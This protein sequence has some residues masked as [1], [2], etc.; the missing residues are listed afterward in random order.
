MEKIMPEY[1][2]SNKN[3]SM[4]Y[5]CN[6]IESEKCLILIHGYMGGWESWKS[7]IQE[8]S[9]YKIYALDLLGFNKSGPLN[10]YNLESWTN[11]II[12]FINTIESK[13]IYVIGHSLGALITFNIANKMSNKI[14]G[15]FLEEPGWIPEF[16][17]MDM[18]E[19]G[20]IPFI[21]KH[22]NEWKTAND[23]VH[24]FREMDPE[25]FDLEPFK[26]SLRAIYIFNADMNVFKLKIGAVYQ[27][28]EE[29]AKNIK[30]KTYVARANPEKGG[31]LPLDSMH[32]IQ[33]VNPNIVFKDFD[34]AHS[35]KTEMP[36]Q[37][38]DFLRKLIV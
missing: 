37:Y 26:S 4:N 27:D 10:S 24:S 7:L 12:D 29:L 1:E 31:M 16:K 17:T 13:S 32:K 8:F 6:D 34:T 23:A 28:F 3:Y 18:N 21:L 38:F 19:W 35:V 14:S 5:F 11:P 33:S 22:K 20:I 15:A 2:Y 9:E 25:A 36:E 30:V